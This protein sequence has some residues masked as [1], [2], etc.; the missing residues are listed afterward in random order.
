MMIRFK[1]TLCS[2][3]CIALSACSSDRVLAPH[4]VSI[5]GVALSVDASLWRDFQP[6]SPPDGKPLVA[7]L[8]V[9]TI[10]GTPIPAGLTADSA[11]IHNGDLVWGV[12][13]AEEQPRG[14]GASF[15]EVVARNGPKWGPGVAV[16]VVIQLRDT[17]GRRFLVQA[18]R[19]LIARTD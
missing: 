13:V 19:Q 17:A 2:L 1:L 10:D 18:P 11:W 7:I 3:T 4:I 5:A 16:D 15:F 12:A 8:A 6:I 9:R 14:V